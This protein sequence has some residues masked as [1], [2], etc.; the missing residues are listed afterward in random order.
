MTTVK[1]RESKNTKR[2]IKAG[3]GSDKLHELTMNWLKVKESPIAKDGVARIHLNVL[4]QLGLQTGKTAAVSYGNG[5]LLVH[6]YADSLIEEDMISLRP[7]DRKKLGVQ[8]GNIVFIKP[9]S[10]I[11]MN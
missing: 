1:K 5:S 2:P 3:H 6:I 4:H 7:G 8:Y 10:S 9:Y 11:K